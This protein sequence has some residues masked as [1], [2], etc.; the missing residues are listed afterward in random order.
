MKINSKYVYIFSALFVLAILISSASAAEKLVS[1]DF[2]NE[3]FA[4]DVPSGSDFNNAANTNLNIGDFAMDLAV[5]ENNGGNSNDVSTVMYL[6]DSSSNQNIIDDAINDLKKEG[7]VIEETDKYF[8]VETKNSND[9]DFFNWDIGNDIDNFFSVVD[10]I[11]SSDSNINV[12]GEDADVQ[13]S[14]ADGIN[15]VDNEN[16]T[17][18]LSDKGL[19][20]SDADGEDVSISNEGVKVS[21]SASESNGSEVSED[22]NVTV[23]GHAFSSIGNDDY[24]ICIK[25]PDDGQMVVI[26]GNNLDLIKSMAET[27][28]FS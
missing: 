17:V 3:S 1:N 5:F 16:T 12:S 8:V 20:V 6:K 15:I 14:S 11:F 10:G 28:S 4:M 7:A 19:Q 25:N 18:S 9:W 24:A 2:D 27:V 21:S 26:T 13:V 22:V 23:D